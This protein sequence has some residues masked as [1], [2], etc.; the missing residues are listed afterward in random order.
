VVEHSHFS[1]GQ[2]LLDYCRVVGRGVVVQKEPVTIFIHAWTNTSNSVWEPFHYTFVVHCIDS[3][4]LR[5]KLF[6]NYAL[7][8]EE[9]QQHGFHTRLLKSQFFRPWRGFCDP[10]SGLTFSVRIV[11]KTPRLIASYNFLKEVRITVCCGN[12]IS[13]SCSSP[14][15]LLW[16]Q[17]VWNKARTNHTFSQIFNYNLSHSVLANVHLVC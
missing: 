5:N 12:Q 16:S 2:K 6:V 8:V 7:T 13:A 11:G 14:V 9:H 1:L 3:F 4:T 15:F 17:R 10:C